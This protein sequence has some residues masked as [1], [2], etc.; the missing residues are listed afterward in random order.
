MVRLVIGLDV[1]P[2]APQVIVNDLSP[3]RSRVRHGNECLPHHV[4]WV[5]RFTRS[6]A[7]IAG[8]Y[9]DERFFDEDHEQDISVP[10]I[11]SEEGEVEVAYDESISKVGRILDRDIDQDIGKL[12]T[13]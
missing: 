12:V 9:D 2:G 3:H 1:N 10:C 6:E 13:K 11:S 4:E 8:Q 7:V 5:D